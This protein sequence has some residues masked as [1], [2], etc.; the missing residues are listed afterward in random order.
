MDEIIK[1]TPFDMV[2]E[3]HNMIL[4][5]KEDDRVESSRN[6]QVFVMN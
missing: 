1:V 3:G 6:K 4:L 2:M 5:Q